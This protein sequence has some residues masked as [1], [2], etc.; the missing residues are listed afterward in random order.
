MRSAWDNLR[1]LRESDLGSR[2]ELIGR[3]VLAG[4]G[5]LIVSWSASDLFLII[6]FL[7]YLVTQA[8][9]LGALTKA[10]Q[11]NADRQYPIVVTLNILTAA[12]FGVLPIYLWQQGTLIMQ[13]CAIGVLWGWCIYNGARYP[14]TRAIA[15]WDALSVSAVVMYF[16]ISFSAAMPETSGQ[17]VPAWLA[18]IIVVYFN[19]SMLANYRRANRLDAAEASLIDRER[20]DAVGQITGGVAHD[21]NNIL[22]AILGQIGLYRQ[23]DDPTE[24]ETAIDAVEAAAQR[25]ARLTRKLQAYAQLS[26][27]QPATH[28]IEHLI[29]ET[30]TQLDLPDGRIVLNISDAIGAYPTVTIDASQTRAVLLDLILNALEASDD[31][32][33]VRVFVD[34]Q[35]LLKP[36]LPMHGVVLT[37]GRYLVIE[38][39]DAGRGITAADMRHVFEPFYSTKTSPRS[40]GLGLAMASGFA[41]QA[42]GALHVVS[43]PKKGTIVTLYLPV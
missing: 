42:G 29:E 13:A 30:L 16:A 6:W 9:Y 11:A 20:L 8:L 5:T 21:F 12:T 17:S 24:R 32:Q 14:Q 7:C 10:T 2:S 36:S 15:I 33:L 26:V 3:Y 35:D 37:Q 31:N 19:L 25:A 34:Y 23:A 39:A 4:V 18:L 43:K 38:V 22:T 28:N 40:S 41:R 27:L 1:R